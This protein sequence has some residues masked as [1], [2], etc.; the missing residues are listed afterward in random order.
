ME[1]ALRSSARREAAPRTEDAGWDQLPRCA[2]AG[3]WIP[4]R[5]GNATLGLPKLRGAVLGL[6]VVTFGIW[7]LLAVGVNWVGL[8]PRLV[9][10]LVGKT[11]D[12]LHGE[13]WRL[14]TAP[15]IHIWSGEAAVS[16]VL[17]T[18]VVLYFFGPALEA[19]WGWR[20]FLGFAI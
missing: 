12:V 2:P 11:S 14:F 13:A 3:S 16:H 18:L 20:R 7:L 5:I 10:P 15:F 8:D 17:T 1:P 4:M 19:R 9:E 6:L